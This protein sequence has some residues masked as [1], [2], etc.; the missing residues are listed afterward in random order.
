MPSIARLGRTASQDH[1]KTTYKLFLQFWEMPSQQRVTRLALR[2]AEKNKHAMSNLEHTTC[3]ICYCY[4]TIEYRKHVRVCMGFAPSS[5]THKGRNR[6]VKIRGPSRHS[7]DKA[8]ISPHGT[9]EKRWSIHESPK[10]S[11]DVTAT[12]LTR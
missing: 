8:F 3:A 2:A 9:H 5:Y 12:Q 1:Y 11:P 4:R 10:D 7:P 6:S